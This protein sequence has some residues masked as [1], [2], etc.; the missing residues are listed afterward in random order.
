MCR[1]RRSKLVWY[2]RFFLHTFTNRA[3]FCPS[4][5]ILSMFCHDG[6]V[7]YFVEKKKSLDSPEKIGHDPSDVS[8]KQESTALFNSTAISRIF[9]LDISCM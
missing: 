6:E 4:I 1:Y 8:D 2:L 3:S 9:L 5:L 7:S